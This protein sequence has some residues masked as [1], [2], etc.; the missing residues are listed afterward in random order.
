VGVPCPG[1]DA[2]EHAI[3]VVLGI[4]GIAGGHRAFVNHRKEFSK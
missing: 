2:I 4:Y 3:A 1:V